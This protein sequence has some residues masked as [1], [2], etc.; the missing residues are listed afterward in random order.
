VIHENGVK[1]TRHE[2]KTLTQL[3]RQSDSLINFIKMS[4][5]LGLHSK[6]LTLI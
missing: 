2:F 4:R 3:Y 5:E 1:L 6:K